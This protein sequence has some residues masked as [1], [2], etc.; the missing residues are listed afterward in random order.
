MF[1]KVIAVDF[2]TTKTVV[3]GNNGDILYNEPSIVAVNTVSNK[4]IAIGLEAQRTV[5]KTP[6]NITIAYPVKEGVISSPK[7]ASAVLSY[8]IAKILKNNKFFKPDLILS[9]PVGI[10]SVEKRAMYEA[11]M[12]AGAREVFL[13]P[14]LLCAANGVDMDISSPFGNTILSIGGGITELGIMSL[15]GLVISNSIRTGGI[16][17][18][19][20][21]VNY[22]KK[23]LQLSVG[24]A[25][26]ENVKMTIGN[27]L[28]VDDQ[29]DI[30]VRGRDTS[31]NMP[32][33]I[34]LKTNEVVE[35]IKGNI[36]GVIVMI[37][38]VMEKTPPEL[39]S[40][41]VD[42]GIMVCGGTANIPNICAVL[43]KNIGVSFYPAEE[44]ELAVARGL[45]KIINQP[46]IYSSYK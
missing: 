21:I 1:R 12:S 30:E 22:I 15:N 34:L 10:T 2:G 18:T 35:P 14:S 26:A 24:Y 20:S 9:I 8:L 44:P 28:K 7:V 41:I 13:V 6:E 17:I 25:M 40:D 32:K 37:K 16:N 5:G 43:T 31:T 23:H 11:G 19:E 33:T 39:S 29:K 46:E 36:M 42:A 3:V 45:Q 38:Q 27:S 4:V